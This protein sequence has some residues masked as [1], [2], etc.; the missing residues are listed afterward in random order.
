MLTGWRTTNYELSGIYFE[1]GFL[2]S[3]FNFGQALFVFLIFGFDEEL[4]LDPLVQMYVALPYAV[5]W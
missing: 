2:D 1:I 3:V 5:V 4:M